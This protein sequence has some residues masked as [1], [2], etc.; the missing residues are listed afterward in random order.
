MPIEGH[1]KRVKIIGRHVEAMIDELREHGLD[2]KHPAVPMLL[3][4]DERFSS[5]SLRVTV[6]IEDKNR[7]GYRVTVYKHDNESDAPSDAD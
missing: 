1:D 6:L 3:G 7:P 5:P 2:T 4:Y